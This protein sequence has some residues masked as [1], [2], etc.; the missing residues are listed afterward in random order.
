MNL[1]QNVDDGAWG[2]GD[3]GATI[4]DS[5]GTPVE[6]IFDLQ[7]DS[8]S[9]AHV[10]FPYLG[11]YITGNASLSPTVSTVLLLGNSGEVS[12]QSEDPNDIAGIPWSIYAYRLGTHYF[13]PAGY[14]YLKVTFTV[15][16]GSDG[17]FYLFSPAL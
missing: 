9:A 15:P 11:I 1:F 3:S 16:A 10:D 5:D 13:A 7:G 4:R 12:G 17:G 6:Y 14:R 8:S 2:F